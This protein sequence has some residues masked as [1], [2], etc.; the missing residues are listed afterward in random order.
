MPT[1]KWRA[2]AT[3]PHLG[4]AAGTLEA[5]AQQHPEGLARYSARWVKGRF[6]R[7]HLGWRLALISSLFW[8]GGASSCRRELL[9]ALHAAH[10]LSPMPE[11]TLQHSYW[12]R[13]L[14]RGQLLARLGGRELLGGALLLRGPV[15]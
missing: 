2:R 15:G 7:L 6:N 4:R 5:S 9:P 1:V 13:L 14:W 10:G 8:G 12:L 3:H 11:C